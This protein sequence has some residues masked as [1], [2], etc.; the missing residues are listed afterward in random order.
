[1]HLYRQVCIAFIS[2]SLWEFWHLGTSRASQDPRPTLRPG[3]Q[4]RAEHTFI[5]GSHLLC[6]RARPGNFYW[7]QP[8]LCSQD[9]GTGGASG[10]IQAL[11][12]LG[13]ENVCAVK[14][15]PGSHCCVF[16]R[17]LCSVSSRCTPPWCIGGAA[18]VCHRHQLPLTVSPPRA[19]TRNR[20]TRSIM[21]CCATHFVQQM[22]SQ[23][24]CTQHSQPSSK[25]WFRNA[26]RFSAKA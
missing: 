23:P 26:T 4:T 20:L 1:M 25:L 22:M 7:R 14:V 9:T 15:R 12:L 16:M 10:P 2:T 11:L 24:C 8:G 17:H 3:N 6:D 21:R 19:L 18:G 13:H 5:D